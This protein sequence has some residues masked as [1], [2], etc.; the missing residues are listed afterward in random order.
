MSPDIKANGSIWSQP[1]AICMCIYPGCWRCLWG[2]CTN[3][4]SPKKF[5]NGETIGIQIENKDNKCYISWYHNDKPIE[6]ATNIATSY[7]KAT[8]FF[9]L[10]C[11]AKVSLIN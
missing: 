10:C 1:G 11:A 6:N 9:E 2:A 5:R 7:Q 4:V 8:L 3:S